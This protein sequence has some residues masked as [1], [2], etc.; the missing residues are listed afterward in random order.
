MLVAGAAHGSKA[1]VLDC[2]VV[3]ANRVT[4]KRC[5]HARGGRVSVTKIILGCLGGEFPEHTAGNFQILIRGDHVV[6]DENP[7]CGVQFLDN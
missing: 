5:N 7:Q 3:V 1:G 4:A 2:T 6:A